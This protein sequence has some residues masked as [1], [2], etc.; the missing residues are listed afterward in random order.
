MLMELVI[1]LGNFLSLLSYLSEKLCLLVLR[2][3]EDAC[4]FSV[5][6]ELYT[7]FLCCK[8]YK[9]SSDVWLSSTDV[10]Q[11]EQRWKA[12][13]A[14]AAGNARWGTPAAVA[15]TTPNDN[16]ADVSDADSG[17]P[18][19]WSDSDSHAI[20][21]ATAAPIPTSTASVDASDSLH[22]PLMNHTFP[23]FQHLID[24]AIMTKKKRE[25]MDD[26][27][28]R[29]V[30]LSLGATIAPISHV[31]HLSNSSRVT[32]RDISSRPNVCISSSTART[33]SQKGV[34]SRGR[35]I[36]HLV[37]LSQQPIRAVK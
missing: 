24:R 23:A 32:L 11:Q 1:E 35:I 33:V 16:R 5:V 13:P 21:A 12:C 30:D 29:L 36:R 7:L 18:N 2:V 6:E 28:R 14:R 9:I 34:S 31:I 27:K 3:S 4:L 20:G 10:R 26:R 25:E 37:F 19:D 15:S 8:I 17:S 22:Y